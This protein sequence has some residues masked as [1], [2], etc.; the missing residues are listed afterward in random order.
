[1]I[2]LDITQDVNALEKQLISEAL[3]SPGQKRATYPGK[4]MVIGELKSSQATNENDCKDMF[5]RVERLMDNYINLEIKQSDWIVLPLD[6]PTKETTKLQSR[7]IE[8]SCSNSVTFQD[9]SS[10]VTQPPVKRMC[11]D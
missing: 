7:S 3:A 6:D 10:F 4:S 2:S 11:S 9:A 8:Q 1:L 5:G